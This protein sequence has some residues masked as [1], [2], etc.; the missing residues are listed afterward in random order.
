M[1]KFLKFWLP[2]ILWA[3]V[4]FWLS[5]IPDLESGLKQDFIL[6]K[7]AHILEY[8]ILTFLLIRNLLQ[9][10]LSIK[11]I[12]IYSIIFSLFYS[13][14]DEYHQTFVLGRQGSLKDAGIDSIGILLMSLV[15]YYKNR[16][17]GFRN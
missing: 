3:G 15:W 17:V 1:S 4:I 13:L 10:K 2:V 16:K 7:I 14:S 6:R 9:E 5:S 11:K 12:V 8:A